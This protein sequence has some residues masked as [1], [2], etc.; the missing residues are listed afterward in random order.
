MNGIQPQMYLSIQ[1]MKRYLAWLTWKHNCVERQ[2]F[3]IGLVDALKQEFRR[4]VNL[5]S[6]ETFGRWLKP[7]RVQ[8]L[9]EQLTPL[10]WISLRYHI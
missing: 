8:S 10:S 3:L 9:A 2:W 4:N 5:L 7:Y 6:V 1:R